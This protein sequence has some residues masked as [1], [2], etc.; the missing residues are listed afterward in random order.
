MRAII[1]QIE[2]AY[3]IA[4]TVVNRIV[5]RIIVTNPMIRTRCVI[6]AYDYH[7]FN[8]TTKIACK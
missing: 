7:Q 8:V 3:E 2:W 1:Q 5:S 4:A 6:H